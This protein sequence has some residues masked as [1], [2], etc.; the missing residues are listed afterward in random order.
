MSMSSGS[1]SNHEIY[2]GLKLD[3]HTTNEVLVLVTMIFTGVSSIAYF[4]VFTFSVLVTMDL[5][6][7]SNPICDALRVNEF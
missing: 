1:F 7:V 4:H 2:R 5:T 6:G 3:Q